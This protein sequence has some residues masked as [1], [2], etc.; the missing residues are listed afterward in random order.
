MKSQTA[1]RWTFTDGHGLWSPAPAGPQS[2][3][4]A[5]NV[6]VTI[7]QAVDWVADL[8]E[9]AKSKGADVIEPTAEAQDDWVKITEDTVNQ[10]LYATTDSWYR[11][12]NV[13]GKPTT[14]LG[15]VGGVG[16]YRRMCTALAKHGYPGIELDGETVA[17]RIGRIDE[18]IA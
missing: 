8:I 1:Q 14:F 17:R 5:S 4:L 13:A 18:E 9:H 10:T 12:S 15:Y 11:G 16:K 3:A 7:E 6:V 2:P